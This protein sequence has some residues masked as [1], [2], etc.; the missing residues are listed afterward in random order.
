MCVPDSG[1]TMMMPIVVRGTVTRLSMS[2]LMPL[3]RIVTGSLVVARS[4]PIV[5]V[6]TGTQTETDERKDDPT[7]PTHPRCRCNVTHPNLLMLVRT[8]ITLSSVH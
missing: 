8:S 1:T 5:G 2:R 7:R 6:R 3:L 4:M